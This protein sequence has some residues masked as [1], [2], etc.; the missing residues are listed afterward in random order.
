M[1]E[2]KRAV[3]GKGR[4]RQAGSK[5]VAHSAAIHL[6]T[7]SLPLAG[8]RGGLF[9]DN[10]AMF[11][12]AKGKRAKEASRTREKVKVA[13]GPSGCRRG[14]RRSL[15]HSRYIYGLPGEGM[16]GERGYGPPKVEPVFLG[17][18]C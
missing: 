1:E 13:R 18:W 4:R 7:R 12:A 2:T 10:L 5:A 15:G 11:G 17:G 16:P 9:F 3:R 14:N 8:V 6:N